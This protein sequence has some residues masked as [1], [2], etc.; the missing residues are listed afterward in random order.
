[1]FSRSILHVVPGLNQVGN[2]IA[3]AAQLIARHQEWAKCAEIGEF[4]CLPQS[5]IREFDEIWVHS[6]WRPDVLWACA[7]VIRAGIPLVRMPHGNLD[8]VRLAYHRWKKLPFYFIERRIYRRTLKVVVTCEE[9][10]EWCRAWGV[11]APIEVC[12]LK[13]FFNLEKGKGESPA[14][15]GIKGQRPYHL[16]YLGRNHPLKDMDLLV[17]AVR[18][19]T[20]DALTARSVD[21]KCVSN[22]SGKALEEDWNWCD[23][24]VLPTRTENFGLVIAE[25]LERGKYVLTTDGAVAWVSYFSQNPQKGRIVHYYRDASRSARRNLLVHELRALT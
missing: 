22:H 23:I 15:S 20:R 24:L 12:D 14:L 9:E 11:S 13:S 21:L 10:A 5:K 1:M 4:L 6:N 3:V 7:R 25:A 2:G 16:L 8:P 19:V 18:D 17:E